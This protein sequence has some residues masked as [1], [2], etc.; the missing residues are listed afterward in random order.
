M[1]R[2]L[3]L[4]VTVS[5]MVFPGIAG[6]KPRVAI[7]A[8]ENDPGGEVQDV[9]ISSLDGDLALVGPK[10]VN[11]TVDK[12]GLDTE[13]SDKDLKKLAN[14][15]E[16]DAIVQGKVSSAK[17][18]HKLLHFKLF[19]HGKRQ[20]GFKIEFANVNSDRFKSALHDK[21]V[22]KLGGDEV[23][24]TKV[25]KNKKK[26]GGDDD[27]AE[28]KSAKKKKKGGDDDEVAETKPSKKKKKG[29][30]ADDDEVA[31]AKPAKK[32]KGE[33]AEKADKSD[34]AEAE[35]KA[36]KKKGGDDEDSDTKSALKTKKDDDD[37]KTAK[38]DEDSD[39]AKSD[40][41][42]GDTKPKKKRVAHRD[43]DDGTSVEAGVTVGGRSGP[44][45]AANAAIR[46]DAGMSFQN[47]SLTFNSRSFPEAPKAFTIAPVPGARVSG[48]LYPL[49]LSNPHSPAAGLGFAGLYD[50]TL[51]LAL[52][53]SAQPGASFPVTEKQWDVGVRYRYL[54]NDSPTSASVTLGVG[55]GH[56][57]FKVDRTKLMN[58]VLI[59]IPDVEYMAYDPSL[60]IRIPFSPSFAF[61]ANGGTLLMR[62]TG[63][64][65]SPEQYGQAKVTAG[66]GDVGFDIVIKQR[67]AL[68]LAGEF[69]QI[70]FAFTGTGAQTKSRDNDSS[71]PDV[72]G[73]TDRY[74]GGSATLAVM[75]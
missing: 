7:V 36:K 35:P 53:N 15:L 62:K 58:G 65:Q 34:E 25:V 51:S 48:E 5:A 10:E 61:F 16:A 33:K 75:Y 54:F 63:Q 69:T 40:E 2:P 46:V 28:P 31:D 55:Y 13:M 41:D 64:I 29:A 9:V 70:G 43:D 39:K 6:A 1:N 22:E 59:D 23:G 42:E 17:D 56:K 47:R 50:Q 67:Y 4:V 72:G 12:L 24:E 66:F 45:S 30:A 20:K 60:G 18:D 32:K 37:T 44:R 14:E 73:A 68:R 19:V 21:M 38:S 26:K 3:V 49:A 11:R 52:N 71:S 74:L 57:Q 8:L 27:E